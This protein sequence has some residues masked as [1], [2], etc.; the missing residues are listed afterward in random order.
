MGT[1]HWF[2]VFDAPIKVLAGYSPAGEEL[3]FL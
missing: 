1:S 3:A 2:E